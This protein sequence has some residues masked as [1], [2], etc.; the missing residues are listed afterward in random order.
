M[1]DVG[2]GDGLAL[3]VA[4]GAAVVIDVGPDPRPMRACLDRLRITHIPLLVLTH[5]HADHINGLAG[6]LRGRTVDAIATA[7]GE[8]RPAIAQICAVANRTHESASVSVPT[9]PNLAAATG[10]PSRPTTAAEEPSHPV[11]SS[12]SPPRAPG[13]I[14]AQVPSADVAVSPL[15]PDGLVGTPSHSAP[16]TAPWEPESAAASHPVERASTVGADARPRTGGDHVVCPSGTPGERLAT[17]DSRSTDHSVSQR[18]SHGHNDDAGGVERVAELAGA[19]GIPLM[20]LHAGH[21]M[22]FGTVGLRVLAPSQEVPT[23]LTA[24]E[25]NDR[26]LVMRARTPAGTILFTGDIEAQAQGRL[27][28]ESDVRADIL[29]VP[30]HGSRTTTTEFLRAVGPRLALVSAGSGNTFGHPH[31]TVTTAFAALGTSVARTDLDGDVV[32]VGTAAD[33][34][35]V[36]SRRRAPRARYGPATRWRGARSQGKPPGVARVPVVGGRT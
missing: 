33:L 34:R 32:V 25:A 35:T 1:C 16:P 8:L 4:P 9:P 7:P 30:H 19:A 24:D 21:E 22:T 14:A 10:T 11:E 20:E 13:V 23:S 17:G 15:P 12:V 18:E 3:S 28:R 6:A 5:P 29:K 36:T 2:Q 31:P 26:S 27:L